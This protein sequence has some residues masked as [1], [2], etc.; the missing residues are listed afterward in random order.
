M[1]NSTSC[2]SIDVH[3][4]FVQV[5]CVKYQKLAKTLSN[6][7]TDSQWREDVAVGMCKP[8]PSQGINYSGE[9]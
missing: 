6:I 9:S 3:F 5:L 2:V 4:I 1:S 7:H 8:D